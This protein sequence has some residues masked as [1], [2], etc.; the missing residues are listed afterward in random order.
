M[1][2]AA[3]E[4]GEAAEEEDDEVEEVGDRAVAAVEAAEAVEGVGEASFGRAARTSS[5]GFASP[6]M[7]DLVPAAAEAGGA[8]TERG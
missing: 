4:G 2:E 3:E 8:A 1:A 6:K 5:R 7:D